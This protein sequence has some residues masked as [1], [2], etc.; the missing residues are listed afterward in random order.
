MEKLGFSYCRN[1]QGL[2]NDDAIPISVQPISHVGLGI[3][4]A[5][6]ASFQPTRIAELIEPRAH[7]DYRLF[8]YESVGCI[9]AVYANK[10]FQYLFRMV[11]RTKIPPTT[12]PDM[13]TFLAAFSPEIRSL[14]SHGYG[15]SLYFRDY[16]VQRAIRSA[17]K[18]HELDKRAVV[19]GI[20][21]AYAMINS[22]D[23]HRVLDVGRDL[24]DP[25][26]AG[27]F[28]DGLT[29][30]LTFWEWAFPGFLELLTP[31]SP[32]Q[33]EFIRI[34]SEQVVECR[35]NGALSVFGVAAS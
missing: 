16:N 33:Q 21:F 19:Q 22:A 12:L 14:I 9:W 11:S 6:S 8:P 1:G 20:A 3:A 27:G 28:Q 5:E 26:L 17:V 31:S 24:D 4:A 15:R 18:L 13:A 10:W 23:I 32:R 30:A 25:E 7:P 29:Y 35:A 2:L 34:A